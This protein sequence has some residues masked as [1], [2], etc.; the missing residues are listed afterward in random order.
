MQTL[1]RG[2]MP[3]LYFVNTPQ[4]HMNRHWV[5]LQRL[6]R[7]K[8]VLDF[9]RHA[10]ARL[11]DLT[12]CAFDDAEPGLLAKVSG[13][14]SAL[15]VSIRSVFAYALESE[16][17][18]QLLFQSSSRTIDELRT[19]LGERTIVLITLIL[20][21]PLFGRER[22][23]SARLQNR[24]HHELN[25]VLD[26][27]T[28]VARLMAQKRRRPYPPLM[29]HEVRA[30]AAPEIALDTIRL[31]LRTQ[32]SSGVL[33]RTASALAAMQLNIRIAQINTLPDGTTDDIFYLRHHSGRT[34]S[35][36]ESEQIATQLRAT[37][38]NF[39]SPS[40]PKN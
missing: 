4:S 27:E 12:L 21:E 18:A 40:E 15:G 8:L 30:E 2:I 26:G 33:L 5:L 22:A 10:G 29:V 7:E 34:L 38:Q 14:M 25:R 9:H 11:T 36:D 32:D 39:T 17:L 20:S 13:T 1:L 35:N 37:L 6:E 28:T 24:A 31:S 19:I 16:K 3:D 23:L